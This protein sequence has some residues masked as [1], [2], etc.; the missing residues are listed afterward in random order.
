M[1]CSVS[2]FIKN[3]VGLDK[4]MIDFLET[5]KY[6]ECGY[7]HY[8][9][10]TMTYMVCSNSCCKFAASKRLLLMLQDLQYKGIGKATCDKICDI[11]DLSNPLYLFAYD[12]N[13]DGII[14]DMSY[15][16]C[17]QLHNFLKTVELPLWK[18]VYIANI[19]LRDNALK[20]F[21]WI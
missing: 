1:F 8:V 9:N 11:V 16:K 4:R 14:A 7:E 2:E 19:G 12:I 10:T 13:E 18:Y 3:N 17:L 6:C 15:E 5:N 21:F 20:L